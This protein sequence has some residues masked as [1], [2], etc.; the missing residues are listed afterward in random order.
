MLLNSK[1][2]ELTAFE[3]DTGVNVRIYPDGRLRPEE[4]HIEIIRSKGSAPIIIKDP[5]SEREADRES[6]DNANRGPG[7]NNRS[8]NNNNRRRNSDSYG[9]NNNNR[10]NNNRRRDNGRNNPRRNN[11]SDDRNLKKSNPDDNSSRESVESKPEM[12]RSDQGN[13]PDPV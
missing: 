11:D 12:A 5:T 6:R 13:I 7:G 3:T 10:R 2:R 9:G 1:R 8:R 4:Y